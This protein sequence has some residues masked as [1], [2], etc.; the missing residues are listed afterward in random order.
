[1]DNEQPRLSFSHIGSDKLSLLFCLFPS[2]LK[3]AYSTALSPASNERM[4]MNDGYES[5]WKEAVM[6]CP[7]VFCP[8]TQRG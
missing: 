2:L 7:F 4:I 1:M 6:T 3:N 8:L 5:M